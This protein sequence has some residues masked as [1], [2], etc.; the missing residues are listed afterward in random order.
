MVH[1]NNNSCKGPNVVGKDDVEMLTKGLEG[2]WKYH[3][4]LFI[5]QMDFASHINKVIMRSIMCFLIHYHWRIKYGDN[6]WVVALSIN[7][8]KKVKYQQMVKP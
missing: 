6:Y 5:N 2:E 7:M 4:Q 1:C 8:M 3:M